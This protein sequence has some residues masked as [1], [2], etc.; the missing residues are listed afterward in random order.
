[1]AALGIAAGLVLWW[2][3]GSLMRRYLFEVGVADPLMLL[4]SGLL[5]VAAL[6]ALALPSHRATALNPA[7]ALRNP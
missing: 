2:L 6:L 1:V 7:Q 3:T 5:C 4:A